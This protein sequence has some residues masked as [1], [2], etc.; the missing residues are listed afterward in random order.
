MYT[1][2]VIKHS[3]FYSLTMNFI[4]PLISVQTGRV[5]ALVVR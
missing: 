3:I 4:A 5:G 2:V 1:H